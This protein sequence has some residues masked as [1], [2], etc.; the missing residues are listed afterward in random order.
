MHFGDVD[1]CRC[2][3]RRRFASVVVPKSTAAIQAL[4]KRGVV[5]NQLR[6]DVHNSP[7]HSA[8]IWRAW[9]ADSHAAANMLINVCGFDLEGHNLY[10]LTC[11]LKAAASN[12][13]EA[14]R[15]FI[16]AGADMNCVGEQ[17]PNTVARCFGL[18]I[19]G[20]ARRCW[21]RFGQTGSHWQ[22]VVSNSCGE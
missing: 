4:L 20:F 8:A 14:L 21:C 22:N 6:D 5:W 12:G 19:R 11:T 17:W 13:H 2:L 15:C 3:T 18:S 1:Q 9:S 7:L 16:N 10:G